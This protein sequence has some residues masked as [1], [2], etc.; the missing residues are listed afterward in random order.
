VADSQTAS[1]MLTPAIISDASVPAACAFTTERKVTPGSFRKRYRSARNPYQQLGPRLTHQ[2]G[3]RSYMAP[4]TL[5][6]EFTLVI[7]GAR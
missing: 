4:I 5:A 7:G 2:P 3:K 6:M 1:G